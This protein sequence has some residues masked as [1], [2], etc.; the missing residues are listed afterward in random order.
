VV[1]FKQRKKSVTRAVPGTENYNLYWVTPRTEVL[2]V[3]LRQSPVTKV[4]LWRWESNSVFATTRT[5][6]PTFKNITVESFWWCLIC[7]PHSWAGR[8]QVT[9]EITQ[10]APVRLKFPLQESMLRLTGARLPGDSTPREE[11]SETEFR[12]RNRQTFC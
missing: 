9:M 1:Y 7:F 2:C 5:S 4:P 12:T 10:M 11:Q 8:C 6:P 3:L